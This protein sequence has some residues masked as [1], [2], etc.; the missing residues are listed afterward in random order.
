MWFLEAFR[1]EDSSTTPSVLLYIDKSLEQ[2]K[3]Y[4]QCLINN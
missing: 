2:L 4:K 3:F 1:V